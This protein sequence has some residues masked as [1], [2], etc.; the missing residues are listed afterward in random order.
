MIPRF[1]GIDP[2]AAAAN[3]VN[4]RDLHVFLGVKS[5][6]RNWIKN[7]VDDFGFVENQD[8]TTAVEKYR[9]GERKDYFVSLD[10]AKELFMVERNEKGKQARQY[11]VES[12]HRL[13]TSPSYL[14]VGAPFRPLA[15]LQLSFAL[16]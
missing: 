11:F 5:E 16:F 15:R 14:A 7:R 10:M 8:F 12:E 1:G 4:A 3:T 9:G 2:A 13:R 6:F